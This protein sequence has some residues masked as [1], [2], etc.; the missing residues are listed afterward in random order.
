MTTLAAIGTS[1]FILGFQLA[2]VRN[3]IEAKEDFRQQLSGIRQQKD[4]GIVVIEESLLD[5]LEIHDRMDIEA[6]L[7]PVFVSLSAKED[8]ESMRKLIKKCIG[9]DVWK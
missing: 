8:S 9:I 4:I 6:S 3:T 1:E 2:G 5:R 7:D